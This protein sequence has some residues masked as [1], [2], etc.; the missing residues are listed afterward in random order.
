MN[1]DSILSK[2]IFIINPSF[3]TEKLES[4]HFHA[5]IWSSN[6]GKHIK[7]TISENSSMNQFLF[8]DQ[9]IQQNIQYMR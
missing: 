6:Y 3:L 4:N 7:L 9:S 2:M 8:W 1:L 5:N